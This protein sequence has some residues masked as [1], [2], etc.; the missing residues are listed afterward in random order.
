MVPSLRAMAARIPLRGF[1]LRHNLADA[2]RGKVGMHCGSL[3][4]IV[5]GGILERNPTRTAGA[6]VHVQE[7]PSP[8]HS[9]ERS[10]G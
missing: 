7:I 5:S 9:V 8:V 6:V 2:T 1:A 3:L 10:C 4:P